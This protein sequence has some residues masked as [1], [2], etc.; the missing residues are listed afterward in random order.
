MKSRVLSKLFHGAVGALVLSAI[1]PVAALGQ[2]R[3]VGRPHRSR[4]VVYNYQPRPYVVGSSSITINRGPTWFTNAGLIT[5]T[6][7]R[8]TISATNT[9][10][11]AHLSLTTATSTTRTGIRSRT[12]L[13]DPP[14][15][16][17]TRLIAMTNHG[18][19]AIAAMGCGLE[20]A[21]GSSREGTSAV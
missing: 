5:V 19:A 2:R 10:R 4:I 15:H 6:A 13:I 7:I 14:T 20:F 16:G 3:W 17:L 18:T 12:S 1:F 8:K 11:T 21:C 9:I